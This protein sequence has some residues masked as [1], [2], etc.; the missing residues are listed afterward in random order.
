M[1]VIAVDG[2][3]GSGKSTV[4]KRL[5][6]R[7]GW[8]HLDTGAYYRAATLAALR[9][10]VS[11][12]NE[13]ALLK[14]T[15]RLRFRQEQGRMLLGSED[16]SE[17]IRTPEV[18]AAVSTL[19]AHAR[20]R[21]VIVR[22]QRQWVASQHL[23]AVVE[24]RDIGTVVFPDALLKVWLE[25]SPVERVRRR[26]SETGQQLNEVEKDLARRDLAD[27]GRAASPLKPASDAV[28]LDTTSLAVEAVVDRIIAMLPTEVWQPPV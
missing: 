23:P 14:M 25:A 2:P 24:G 7:L 15:A 19:A 13:D 1:T 6:A 9:E 4:S 10:K 3:S 27:S 12:K 8:R 5:A 18:T 17:E 16:V 26:A 20:L 22:Q 21:A 11:L 28:H